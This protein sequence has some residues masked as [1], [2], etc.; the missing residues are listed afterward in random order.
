M[1]LAI[2]GGLRTVEH[3]MW[4][5]ALVKR[6]VD[7]KMK[8]AYSNSATDKQDALASMV[9]SHVTDDH[10]E[11][12]GRLRNKCRSYR[13]E[14]VDT[15]VEKLVKGGYLRE[16]ETTFGKGRKTKKYFAVIV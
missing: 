2:P 13:K 6:D 10:G 15:V 3:V 5:Y 8:L 1:I 14:D 16:E 11:T 7:E 12:A 4:A 9:M